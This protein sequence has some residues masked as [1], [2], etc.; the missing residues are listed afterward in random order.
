MRTAII[1]DSTAY[2]APS[3]VSHPDIYEVE[4]TTSFEN[5]EEHGDY[6]DPIL[7]EEFYQRLEAA[8]KLPTTSQPSPGKY[9][10][11]VEEIIEK[12]YDQILAIH[13]SAGLSGAYQTAKMITDA[14]EDQIDSR[15]IDSKAAAIV[16]EGMIVQAID[17]IDQGL[18]LDEVYENLVWVAENSTI[19]LT[20]SDLDNLAKGGRLPSSLAKFGN[21]LKIKPL[22]Q[23]GTDGKIQ[24][25]D[26]IRTDK[27]MKKKFIQLVAADLENY[28][29]GLLIGFAHALDEER[30]ES[31]KET[32][33]EAFPELECRTGVLGPVIGTHTGI[34]SIGMGI[35][36]L[37][38]Y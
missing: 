1:I 35:I 21:M 36:P 12:G 30:M 2:A 7:L 8:V 19:Y 25:F 28:P 10:E 29:N 22:L 4:F 14:Y 9:E 17:M 26:Q 15:V 20:V 5:G 32:V 24:L 6:S 3:I 16:I 34:G 31:T 18:T 13:L 37:A 38:S 27:K 23:I 33:L 11:L